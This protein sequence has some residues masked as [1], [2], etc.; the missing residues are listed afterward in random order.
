MSDPP[1]IGPFEGPPIDFTDGK[2]RAVTI[3]ALS[4][5]DE[6]PT[7]LVEMY[8]TFDRSERAQ[9]LPP[10]NREAVEA[11]LRDLLSDEGG[12]N[13]VAEVSGDIVG[14]ATLVPDSKDRHELAI[15]V[16]QA[17]Q[18]A[19]IGTQ[20]LRALLG[21]GA[22]SGVDTVWLTVERWNQAAIALYEHVGFER[23]NIERFT[24]E[25]HA[26]LRPADHED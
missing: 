5:R 16:H 26:T 18:N 6:V 13:V 25:M 10:V 8:D 2:G 4:P 11:W 14:H 22:R 9:G 12:R 24:L 21:Y 20:L 15:F 19:G 23:R 17:Y 7:S 1:P 3:R